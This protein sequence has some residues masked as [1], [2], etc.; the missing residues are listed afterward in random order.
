MLEKIKYLYNLASLI[1]NS[2]TDFTKLSSEIDNIIS[3]IETDYKD[4]SN[5]VSDAKLA[6]ENKDGSQVVNIPPIV[7]NIEGTFTPI[8]DD[9]EKLWSEVLTIK[10]SLGIRG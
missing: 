8:K 2:G 9:I 1:M 3:G 5:I 7:T 6:I 4:V 10:K